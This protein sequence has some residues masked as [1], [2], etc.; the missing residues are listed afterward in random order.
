MWSEAALRAYKRQSVLLT[1]FRTGI[2]LK[3]PLFYARVH[4]AFSP[5]SFRICNKYGIFPKICFQTYSNLS[6]KKKRITDMETSFYS[7]IRDWMVCANHVNL[8]P[9]F[10]PHHILIYRLTEGHL[11]RFS[12][13]PMEWK[14]HLAT[15]AA[16]TRIT[17]NFPNIPSKSN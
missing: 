15:I 5:E 16:R 11:G 3:C 4:V 13:W 17:I 6:V 8:W 7:R 10:H 1:V 14:F 9:G 2:I 12:N